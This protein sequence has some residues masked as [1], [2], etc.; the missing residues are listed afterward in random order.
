[1]QVQTRTKK[2]TMIAMM[3]A[4]A[5]VVMAV[6]RVPIMSIPGL[7]LKFE[8]KDIVI[9]IG[10]FA[11]GPL[12]AAAMSVIVSFIEMITV[13]ETGLPGMLMNIVSTCSFACTASLIYKYRRSLSGAVIG[14]ITGCLFTAAMMVGWNYFIAP[15]YLGFPRA[16]VVPHLLPFF[17]PFN[18]IKVS[19]NA[20]G[21]MLIYKPVSKIIRSMSDVKFSDEISDGKI[22]PAVIITAGLVIAICVAA[23]LLINGVI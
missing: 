6:G 23:I 2:I 10:G 20:A 11:Y 21:V 16:A 3:S 18:L 19:I 22:R 14:L 13:S 9:I 17:L 7:T 12:A 15:I 5:F 4:L 1:M 8:P